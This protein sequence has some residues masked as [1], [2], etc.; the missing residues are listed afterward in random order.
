[1]YTLE[2]AGWMH[3]IATDISKQETPDTDPD[4]FGMINVLDNWIEN[5]L[6]D[7]GYKVR[8]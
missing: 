1:M 5:E 6:Y 2:A 8:E 4:I 3:I 7:L